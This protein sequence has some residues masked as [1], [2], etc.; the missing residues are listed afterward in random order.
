MPN[1]TFIANYRGGTYLFQ[2][3]ADELA[4]ACRVWKQEI[5]SGNYV[6]HLDSEAFAKAFE[7]YSEEF[8][9]GPVNE[10]TNVWDFELLVKRHT[11]EVYIVQTDMAAKTSAVN[12]VA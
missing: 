2:T 12:Q 6:T 10:M 3:A 8:P 1:F 7:V 11:F 9:P 5:I 4:A